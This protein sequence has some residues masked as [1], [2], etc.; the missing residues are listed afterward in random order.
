MDCGTPVR[1]AP[2]GGTTCSR[3]IV[4]ESES[5][6]KLSAQQANHLL[7]SNRLEIPCVY[8][9]VTGNKKR[10]RQPK[11]AAGGQE[12]DEDPEDGED[13]ALS[14]EVHAEGK[15]KKRLSFS[16][17]PGP[18][19]Q[20]V[21]PPQ[22]QHVTSV[23]PQPTGMDPGYQPPIPGAQPFSLEI[24]TLDD[25]VNSDGNVFQAN[26]LEGIDLFPSGAPLLD[27]STDLLPTDNAL[28]MFTQF[29]GMNETHGHLNPTTAMYDASAAWPRDSE[30]PT[31]SAP[32]LDLGFSPLAR[33]T[34]ESHGP[35][36][37]SSGDQVNG[38]GFIVD[39]H[40]SGERYEEGKPVLMRSAAS[41]KRD[42]VSPATAVRPFSPAT[43][44][45]VRNFVHSAHVSPER[46]IETMSGHMNVGQVTTALPAWLWPHVPTLLD[47]RTHAT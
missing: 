36:T 29:Y 16:Q 35:S 12:E 8:Q 2:V 43:A 17:D 9:K 27:P 10:K 23:D 25:F 18:S 20:N 30:I 45:L 34:S 19:T 15:G 22:R 47:V 4:A 41:A 28:A 32:A 3:Q 26:A 46:P 14:S 24:T 1:G 6:Y 44:Q 37:A 13:V 40:D 21:S 11:D 5:S 31:P 33:A 42:Q 38:A 39:P 7:H